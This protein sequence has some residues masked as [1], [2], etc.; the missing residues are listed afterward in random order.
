MAGSGPS[1]PHPMNLESGPSTGRLVTARHVAARVPENWDA[2]PYPDGRHHREG[3]Q[4][5]GNLADR[6]SPRRRVRWLEAFWVDA[7]AVGVP[8]DYYYLA[9]RGPA[10]GRL[11][12]ADCRSER[13]VLVDHAPALDRHTASPGDFVATATGVCR[14]DDGRSRWSAFVAAPGFGPIRAIGIPASGLYFVL[15]VMP[16]GPH[17]AKRLERLIHGVSFG[18]TPVADFITTARATGPAP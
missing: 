14:A 2:R 3:I 17:A 7:T 4:A 15:A 16:E 1:G 8:T 13:S 12:T 11:P 6:A 10:F 5:S 9:A 18:G